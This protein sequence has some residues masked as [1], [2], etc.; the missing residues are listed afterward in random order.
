MQARMRVGVAERCVA[1]DMRVD[2]CVCERVSVHTPGCLPE[3]A[4]GAI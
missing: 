3:A 1:T 4:S 2:L